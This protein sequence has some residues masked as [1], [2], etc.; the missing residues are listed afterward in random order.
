MTGFVAF[1]QWLKDCVPVV[2][3]CGDLGIRYS[4]SYLK[5]GERVL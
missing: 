2:V 3:E 5:F 1:F 4:C